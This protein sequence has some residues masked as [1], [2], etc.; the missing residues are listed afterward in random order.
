MRKAKPFNVSESST[1]CVSIQIP[2]S[3]VRNG[4]PSVVVKKSHT[5]TNLHVEPN[6]ETHAKT[7]VRTFCVQKENVVE[8]TFGS[9]VESVHVSLSKVVGS[10]PLSS[11]T[12]VVVD[13]AD[14]SPK[15]TL[16]KSNVISDVETSQDQ[17]VSVVETGSVISQTD[18][19]MVM[20]IFNLMRLKINLMVVWSIEI[21]NV[22]EETDPDDLPLDQAIAQ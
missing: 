14:G 2:P 21:L 5:M 8:P 19:D 22:V 10:D 1:P 12:K 15:E 7:D 20:R 9:V 16:S 3:D 6:I 18:A 11:P 4:D 17:P 13:S